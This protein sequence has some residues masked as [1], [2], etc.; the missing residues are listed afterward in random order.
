MSHT[1][2]ERQ[3]HLIVALAFYLSEGHALDWTEKSW[4]ADPDCSDG[5]ESHKI[6]VRD[7]A[8]F[9]TIY[10]RLKYERGW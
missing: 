10:T 2:P 1:L 8:A 7:L 9:G 4:Q 3:K 6:V 5:E